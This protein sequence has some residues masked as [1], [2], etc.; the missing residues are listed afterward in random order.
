[1]ASDQESAGIVGRDVEFGKRRGHWSRCYQR[2]A[3]S[4]QCGHG[5]GAPA[6]RSAPGDSWERPPRR[7]SSSAPRSDAR[8][9]ALEPPRHPFPLLERVLRASQHVP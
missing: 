5:H 9:R 4:L 7:G 1:V 8:H 2:P 3:R 6:V